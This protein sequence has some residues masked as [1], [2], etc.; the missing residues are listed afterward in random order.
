MISV[1]NEEPRR[2]GE[3][4][5]RQEDGERGKEEERERRHREKEEGG[6]REEERER[7]HRERRQ[8]Q[9]SDFKLRL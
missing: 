2:D 6:G 5:R 9:V 8:R 4:R 1:K 7:R 3:R